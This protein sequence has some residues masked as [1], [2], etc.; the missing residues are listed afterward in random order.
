MKIF[1][2]PRNIGGMAGTLARAQRDLG[3]DATSV[4]FPTGH[5]RYTADITIEGD[6]PSP[7][8]HASLARP[9]YDVFQFYFGESL[10]GHDLKDVARLRSAGKKVFFYFCGCDIRDAKATI[11]NYPISACHNCWPALCS[12][13]RERALEVATKHTNANFVSTPDLLEFV[14]NSILL[15][16]PVEI[17]V[18]QQSFA[19]GQAG[20]TGSKPDG[21]PIADRPLRVAH[22]PTNRQMKG[23]AHIERAVESLQAKGIPIELVLVENLSHAETL[24]TCATCDLAVD[25]LLFGSYGLFAVEMM[26]IGM[27][28]LCYLREDVQAHYQPNCPVINASPNTIR[29][30]L[31]DLAEQWSTDEQSPRDIADAG[32]LYASQVHDHR[33]V[34]A[35]ML[36]QYGAQVPEPNPTRPAHQPVGAL[37]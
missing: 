19:E 29:D 30:V 25:Q 14:P 8:R 16:Q 36:R 17:E 4:C 24:A 32:R 12:R 11:A 23:S 34:A 20:A 31:A 37:A 5:Y 13:N 26:A 18:I 15:P 2:G 35:T 22:A 6:Q 7:A 1:H 10:S 27:P 28:V 21:R 9:A 33:V 3:F